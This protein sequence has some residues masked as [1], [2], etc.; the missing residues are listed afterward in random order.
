MVIW[1]FLV[2]CGQGEISGYPPRGSPLSEPPTPGVENSPNQ[3]KKLQFE[4]FLF[5]WRPWRWL[6]VLFVLYWYMWT[7]YR[8]Q[9]AV[10][11]SQGGVPLLQNPKVQIHSE[12]KRWGARESGHARKQVQNPSEAKGGK[13][14]KTDNYFNT[15]IHRERQGWNNC[16]LCCLFVCINVQY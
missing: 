13:K 5:E 14:T 4:F 2:K 12:K 11:D 3:K 16:L 1:S 9:F 7:F 10:Q 15:Q 8:A 6:R